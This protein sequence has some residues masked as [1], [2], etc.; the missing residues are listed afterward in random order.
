[1][2]EAAQVVMVREAGPDDPVRKQYEAGLEAALSALAAT[3]GED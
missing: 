1:M 3:I 2:S